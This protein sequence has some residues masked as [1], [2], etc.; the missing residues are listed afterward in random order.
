MYRLVRNRSLPHK[1]RDR[2]EGR[3]R[4]YRRSDRGSTA[5]AT[6][7]AP[8]L[9]PG[10]WQL[11]APDEYEWGVVH[12]VAQVKDP[13][14]DQTLGVICTTDYTP[15]GEPERQLD[16]VLLLEHGRRIPG[17]PSVGLVTNPWT[18]SSRSREIAPDHLLP[19]RYRFS[20]EEHLSD[21]RWV[22]DENL[23]IAWWPEHDATG[24]VRRFA[25]AGRLFLRIEYT[26]QDTVQVEFDLGDSPALTL[27]EEACV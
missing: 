22:T 17:V 15:S 13:V 20:G 27:I 10:D 19:I 21:S 23:T 4:P 2:P 26:Q 1:D 18:V 3:S 11:L 8:D 5:E 12:G 14:S 6:G 7:Q 25:G 9:D 16:V 24:L